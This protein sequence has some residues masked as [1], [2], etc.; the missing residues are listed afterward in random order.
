MT[1]SEIFCLMIGGF[2]T[3]AGG[4]LS[5]YA[6]VLN[7]PA[8]HLITASVMSAPAALLIAKVLLPE[9]EVSATAAGAAATV[10][11]QTI[12][13]ID[14]LC[15]GASDGMKMAIN[16][17]AMLIAFVAVV[18]ALNWILGQGFSML[19]WQTDKP[20]Q[21]ILGYLNV[22]FAWL[23]GVS[24]KDSLAVG[25]M[26]GERIV[27]NEFFGYISLNA[28]KATLDQRSYTLA[29]YALCGFA[30]IGSVAVQVGG[31]G[32]LAPE[33]RADFA[34]IGLKAMAGGLLACY[35]TACVAG[36]LL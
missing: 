23:I 7:V 25:Q 3:V 14:A 34:R 35:M 36:I 20:L 21:Q 19:G 24:A 15:A 22:P 30:N 12:N 5:V 1:R 26:L 31:L 13:A 28:Q 29:A 27:L 18:A 6:G 33:R 32:A 2:A 17:I 9:T 4:V 10:Q 11:K 16:V 8:G